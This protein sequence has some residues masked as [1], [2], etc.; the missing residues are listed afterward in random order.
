MPKIHIRKE[1]VI[2][3]KTGAECSPGLRL[4][5]WRREPAMIYNEDLV[6]CAM[7][8]QLGSLLATFL[9]AE[10]DIIITLHAKALRFHLS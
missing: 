7:N 3:V 9:C 10:G 6:G 8:G 2:I 5:V 4:R 1:G